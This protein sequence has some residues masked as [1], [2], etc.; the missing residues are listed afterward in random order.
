MGAVSC[1]TSIGEKKGNFD[2]EKM[3]EAY[4]KMWMSTA[5]RDTLLMYSYNDVHGPS[6]VRVDRVLQSVDKFYE[7]YGI[8][9]KDGMWVAPEDRVRIW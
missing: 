7:I 2:F 6:N 9:E 4:A 5:S 1:I 8:T 3:Y